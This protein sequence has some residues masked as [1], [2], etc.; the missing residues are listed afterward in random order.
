MVFVFRITCQA[1]GEKETTLE[2]WK[3]LCLS[4]KQLELADPF[5]YNF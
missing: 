3:K 4:R 5:L 1:V 2:K